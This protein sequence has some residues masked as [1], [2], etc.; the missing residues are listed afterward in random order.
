[1]FEVI[2]IYNCSDIHELLSEYFSQKHNNSYHPGHINE[3]VIFYSL[4][5][6]FPFVNIYI[7]VHSDNS[8][9]S[10]LPKSHTGGW[11]VFIPHHLQIHGVL[12]EP[13]QSSTEKSLF[14]LK[15]PKSFCYQHWSST[16]TLLL[17]ICI[18]YW[19]SSNSWMARWAELFRCW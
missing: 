3:Q 14:W 6:F 9:C 5:V 15:G 19:I 18:S 16:H 11:K 4:A 12:T 2:Y 17:H 8:L 13:C 1:M 10:P 7:S